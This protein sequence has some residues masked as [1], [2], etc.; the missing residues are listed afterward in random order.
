MSRKVKAIRWTCE[1]AQSEFGTDAETIS[2]RLRASGVTPGEDGK[3]STR[4]IALA[5]FGDIDGEKLRLAHHQANL[6]EMEDKRQK[7]KLL[8]AAQ[9]QSVWEQHVV[10][11][12]TA[13]WNF[14]AAEDV[15]RRWM[16]ELKSVPVAEYQDAGVAIE[17][18]AE[19]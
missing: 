18:E 12:R 5:V 4:Q 14:D 7:G 6:S 13:V 16:L 3:F 19:E 2:K 9:V 15:R 10:A 1:A 11:L 8:D 17:S